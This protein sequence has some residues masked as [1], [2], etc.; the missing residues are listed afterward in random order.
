MCK[1]IRMIKGLLFPRR[2]KHQVKFC[3]QKT[4]QEICKI[5]PNQIDTEKITNPRIK[6]VIG[7]N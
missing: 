7:L 6:E 1:I 3:K 5:R 2:R 4:W